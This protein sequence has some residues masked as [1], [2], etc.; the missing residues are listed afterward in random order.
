MDIRLSSYN[1][2]TEPCGRKAHMIWADGRCLGVVSPTRRK[3][4]EAGY[5]DLKG[6][7]REFEARTLSEVRQHLRDF[8]A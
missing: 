7:K 5:D 3:T 6:R 4:W 1:Q 2:P 8:Y